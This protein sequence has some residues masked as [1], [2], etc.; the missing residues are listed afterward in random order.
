MLTKALLGIFIAA[1]IK[2]TTRSWL[3]S[4]TVEVASVLNS[5]YDFIVIGSGSAGSVIA[6]RL[7]QNGDVTVLLLE[8]GGHFDE[9]EESHV[10]GLWYKML[11]SDFDWEYYT[12]PQKSCGIGINDRRIYWPRGR[13][14]GGS[15]VIN[16]MQYTR[17]NKY[18]YDEWERLGCKGWGYKDI[19]TYFK[20][21][22]NNVEPGL[23]A[24]DYHGTD[25]P[26]G[27]SSGVV[28][29][30]ADHYIQAGKD[31]GYT[32]RDYNDG[33]QEGFSL[34]Q[35]HIKDGVR[36]S[37]GKNYLS[38]V[39]GK[40]NIHVATN[41][42]VTKIDIDNVDKSAKGVYFVRNNRKFYI[43]ADKEVILSAGAIN[44]P[45][46][47]MLSGIGP[48]DHLKKLGLPVKADLPVGENLQDHGRIQLFTHIDQ[49]ISVKSDTWSMYWNGI[50]YKLFGTGVLG[51]TLA[52]GTSFHY[53]DK[54]QRGKNYTNVQFNFFSSYQHANIE[55]YNDTYFNELFSKTPKEYGFM[56]ALIMNHLKSTGTITL[57][58]SDPFD[59]P[60][61][62]PNY[63]SEKSDLD[64]VVKA[65]RIWER[66]IE[67]PTMKSLGASVDQVRVT[68]CDN[69]IFRSD[70]YWKC[71]I[72]HFFITVYHPCCTCKM[73]APNDKTTVLGPDLRVKG[74]KGLR[75]ADASSFPH[76]TSGNIN[77]PIIM[78]AEKAADLILDS[79]RK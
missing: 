70:D 3:Q 58:S 34:Y 79:W 33:E 23:R 27:V 19:L 74:V 22:E 35:I 29:P 54:S 65:I 64:D 16:L 39:S 52:E 49:P 17:G 5:S 51:K 57:K 78:L 67:T 1:V 46:L 37:T 69:H 62:E 4:G 36:S 14:L 9:M 8:A 15:S 28:S 6:T 47:L 76:E 11:K 53:T 44:S 30:L 48:R 77:A 40:K 45:Q 12:E 73:G 68:S 66:F 56:T 55:S 7:A 71:Y 2:L 41:S 25:G 24:T 75:V 20:R 60:V 18:D 32:I 43:K 38:L 72:R 21:S 59:Y 63:L 31:M 61:I 50:M 13:V 26:M 10:P 42:F